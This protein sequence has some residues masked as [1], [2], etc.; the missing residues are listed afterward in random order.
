[1]AVW[2]EDEAGPFQTLP[3]PG[4]AWQPEGCPSRQ[5]HEYVRRGTAKLLTLFRPAT[6]EVRVKGVTSCTNAVLH[7][8]LEAELGAVLQHLPPAADLPGADNRAAWER[9]QAGLRIKYTLSAHLPPLRLLLI[10]DNLIGHTSCEL[11]LWF[12]AH[13][14]MPLFTP[15][16][17]SWLNMTESVQRVLKHRA[18]DG[19]HPPPRTRSSRDSRPRPTAGMRP[20]R[21]SSGA[22]SARPAANGPTAGVIRSV[23]RVPAPHVPSAVARP[24]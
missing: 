6:G 12:F 8:W 24:S 2:G 14:V 10:L 19:Q 7:P 17:G 13:G 20:R 3:Y 15:L 18:L 1:L 21:R 16:S 22:A 5:P 11:I 9:W 4:A 23:A